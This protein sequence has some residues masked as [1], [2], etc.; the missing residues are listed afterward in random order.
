[1]KNQIRLRHNFPKSAEHQRK[2]RKINS[3]FLYHQTRKRL[4]CWTCAYSWSI[5]SNQDLKRW[6]CI[7]DHRRMIVERSLFEWKCFTCFNLTIIFKQNM[8][9]CPSSWTWFNSKHKWHTENEKANKSQLAY[10]IF[11]FGAK[12]KKNA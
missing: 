2:N 10:L 9:L 11:I 4:Q 3:N 8:N 1:M 12:P 6:I 7:I 5:S